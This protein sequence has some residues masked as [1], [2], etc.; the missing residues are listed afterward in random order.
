MSS[1]LDSTSRTRHFSSDLLRIKLMMPQAGPTW[2]LVL[3]PAM[4][5]SLWRMC[6]H[7]GVIRT[8]AWIPRALEI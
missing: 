3:R 6:C 7:R 2:V 8:R 1:T 4:S 5:A